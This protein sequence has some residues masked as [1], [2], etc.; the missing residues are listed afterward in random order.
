MKPKIITQAVGH[1]LTIEELRKQ[2]EIVPIEADSD[3]NET[4]PDDDAL[5][6]Y[7]DS[8]VEMAEA[9]TGLSIALRTYELA[10][11][12]FP[13]VRTSCWPDR[14]Q[15]GPIEIPNPP[16]VEILNFQ[17]GEDSDGPMDPAT[18][19]LDDYHVPP[20]VR[21][22]GAWPYVDGTINGIKLR[23][24]AGY[25]A[26]DSDAQ[27]MPALIRQALLVTVAYWYENRE[28]NE[29]MPTRAISMLRPLRIRLGMA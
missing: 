3:G 21:P 10:M 13:R 2:C 8:A 27:P 12:E 26:E 7:L 16:I 4:H 18:Y 9:F 20:L 15:S 14:W 19:A 25:S 28:D 23:Y 5:L 1:V 11:S 29:E 17:S 6:G 22:V 24:R